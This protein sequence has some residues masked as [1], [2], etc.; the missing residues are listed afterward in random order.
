M[1]TKSNTLVLTQ[2]SILLA[3]EALFCFTPLGS[4]PIGAIVMT[5]AMIPVIITAILLGTAA[6][7]LM[8]FFTGLFSF[9]VWTF[10]PPPTSAAFAFVF[11]PFYSIGQEQGN[12][13]SLVIC[14]VPRILIGTVTGLVFALLKKLPEKIQWLRY[15]AAGIVG[16]LANT[17][18]VLGG[19]WIFFGARYSS[20]LGTTMSTLLL[21]TLATNGALEMLIS[22]LTAVL[23]CMPLKR[24]IA[25][26]Q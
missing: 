22:A 1:K 15:G 24:A 8:G 3:I 7:T 4:I 20:L 5:T 18:G 26:R 11:T 2:F 16:S 25:R 13:W 23:I 19:I 10:M 21:A 17:V 9:L 6:G 14:F 12:F